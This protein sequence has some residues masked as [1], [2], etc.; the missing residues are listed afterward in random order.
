M[1]FFGGVEEAVVV[2][3]DFSKGGGSAG[4]FGG[5]G[6]GFERGEEGYG[7]GGV[8]IEVGGGT[9]VD[10]DG[11]VADSCW[12]GV[13]SSFP[14]LEPLHYIKSFFEQTSTRY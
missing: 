14:S 3:A 4:G 12:E 11:C 13:S 1:G 7:A 10:A 9:G 5:E 8:G 2:E 6:E